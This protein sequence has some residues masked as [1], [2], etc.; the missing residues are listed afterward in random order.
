M[1]KKLKVSGGKGFF[2]N[3]SSDLKQILPDTTGFS[4]TNLRYIKRFY[5]L[6]A[7]VIQAQVVPELQIDKKQ[8]QVVP[9][10]NI[11]ELSAVSWGHH[12]R[13]IV[14]SEGDFNKAIFY[15]R[16]T[17][18]NNWS[19]AVLEN[20]MDGNLYERH[21]KAISNFELTLPEEQS[22]LAQQITKDPYNFDFMTLREKY[23]E[24]QM[25][26]A[27]MQNITDFL[28]ELGT[29]FSFVG[30][31]YRI[32]VA[33]TE[34]FIDMLFYNIR[35]HCY[36]VIEVKVTDFDPR[37]IGQLSTY[38]SAVNHTLKSD[39]DTPTVGLLV[40]RTKNNV[41]AKYAVDTSTEPI[42]ISEYDLADLLPENVE[43]ILPSIEEIER[44]L[45][46]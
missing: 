26:D 30:R 35:L 31:E 2:E 44:S 41:L 20:F 22:D 4:E 1:R 9:E 46:E 23:N 5:Q 43:G 37:D 25:K 36:V 14:K 32:D 45:Q 33:G 39:I 18:A 19:R 3:L 42:G 38:V 17:I 40:C 7:N 28:L 6:Y 12:R 11:E 29:G 13:I 21:G 27:L 15:V 16:K 10:F 24:K 34:L 8:T